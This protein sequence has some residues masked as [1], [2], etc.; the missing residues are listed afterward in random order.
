MAQPHVERKQNP[1]FGLPHEK[2]SPRFGDEGQP[3]G[4]CPGKAKRRK[5]LE[6]G[7]REVTGEWLAWILFWV[8]LFGVRLPMHCF[9]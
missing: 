5:G 7:E 9:F 4:R 2:V 6:E 8:H 1:S 3:C